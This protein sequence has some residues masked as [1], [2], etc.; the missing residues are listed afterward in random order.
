MIAERLY[1]LA[2]TNNWF[3]NLQADFRKG[4]SCMDQIIRLS[5]AIEDGFQRKSMNH[6]VKVLLDYSKAFDTVWL[7]RLL[8]SMA[9]KV[10]PLEYVKWI[11]SF[12]LNRQAS[13]RLHGTTSSSSRKL[14]QGMSQGCVLSPLLFLCFINNFAE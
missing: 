2:E 3:S 12:L 14:Q 13:V 9:D 11:N 4:H 5:Q 6:A 1:H 8:L 10:V 7:S